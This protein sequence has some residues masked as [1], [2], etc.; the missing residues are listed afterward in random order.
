MHVTKVDGALI[1]QTLRGSVNPGRKRTLK[2]Q[3]NIKMMTEKPNDSKT[4]KLGLHV[5][6]TAANIHL[7]LKRC[8]R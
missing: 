3:K 2:A 5:R 8:V 4:K 6:K 7:V 1:L